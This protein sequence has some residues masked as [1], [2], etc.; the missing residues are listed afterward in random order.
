M[1]SRRKWQRLFAGSTLA[2]VFA[3]GCGASAPPAA[4]QR[5]APGVAQTPP[6]AKAPRLPLGLQPVPPEGHLA[7]VNCLAFSPD[8]RFLLSGSEDATLLLWEVATRAV[9]KRFVGHQGYVS[10]CEFLPSGAI[11]SGGWGGEVWVWDVDSGE[12]VRKLEGLGSADDV[13]SLGV[14]ADGRELMAGSSYGKVGVWD[15]ETGEARPFKNELAVSDGKSAIVWAAGYLSNGTPFA[16]SERG[17]TLLWGPSTRSFDF[18]PAN[19]VPLPGG[20]LL[21]GGATGVFVVEPGGQPKLLGAHEKFVYGLSVSPSGDLVLAGDN[22]GTLRMWKVRGGTAECSLSL[23]SG[24]WATAFSPRGDQF[25]VAGDDGVVRLG[26]TASCVDGRA[27]QPAM[28]TSLAADRGRVNAVA[29]GNALWL[30]DSKGRISAWS[31]A[32]WVRDAV[33]PAKPV[34]AAEVWTLAALPGGGWVSGG[35]DSKVYLNVSDAPKELGSARNIVRAVAATE[36]GTSLLTADDSGDLTLWPRAGGAQRKLLQVGAPLYAV[37]VHPKEPWALAGGRMS[38]VFKVPL[39]GGALTEW[40]CEIAAPGSTSALLFLP[41]GR[42]VQGSTRGDALLRRDATVHARLGGLHAQV[43]GLAWTRDAG[44]VLH[45]WAGG[46]DRTLVRWSVDSA[47]LFPDQLPIDEGSAIGNI[48]VTPDQ[49]YLVSTLHDGRASVRALP[50]G[51]LVAHLYPFA[52]GSGATVFADGRFHVT[53]GLAA[54]LRLQ[55]PKTRRVVTLGDAL[56]PSFGA[57]AVAAL[58]DGSAEVR[59]TVFSPSGPPTVMLDGQWPVPSV[60][61][62]ASVLMAYDVTLQLDSPLGGRYA[63]TATLPEGPDLSVPFFHRTQCAFFAREHAGLDCGQQQLQLRA[64]ARRRQRPARHGTVA[65]RAT[66]GLEAARGAGGKTD[67]P[68]RG[69]T[70]RG[71]GA[72]FRPRQSG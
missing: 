28:L 32:T 19:G 63:L 58:P 45:V 12:R 24:L 20:R 47:S 49:R 50:D 31:L 15:P 5:A 17:K 55:D 2:A 40:P 4:P 35:V 46:N 36:D 54:S 41:D 51:K 65:A 1:V 16:G 30:G 23:P 60:V 18:L 37:A 9:V 61:P 11:V 66:R 7:K 10:A 71:C 14:R 68:Q 33:A 57:V 25:A 64:P 62:S 67:G 52:D 53:G 26:S 27:L 44:G 39:D 69:P 34:H 38:K 42:Y 43:N 22:S 70:A 48:A 56:K 8:G 72:L 21:L 29:A 13:L 3:A 6:E 59:T